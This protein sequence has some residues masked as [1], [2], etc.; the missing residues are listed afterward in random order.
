MM[1]LVQECHLEEIIKKVLEDQ[2][3]RDKSL[4]LELLGSLTEA[5]GLRTQLG[6]VRMNILGALKPLHY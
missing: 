1:A 5:L 3:R 2:L 6:S 4:T